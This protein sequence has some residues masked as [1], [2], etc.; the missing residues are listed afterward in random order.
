MPSMFYIEE[1]AHGLL[2]KKIQRK[3]TPK[4]ISFFLENYELPS[5][6][7]HLGIYA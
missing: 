5:S 2:L 4:K 7:P 6:H 3:P 1:I